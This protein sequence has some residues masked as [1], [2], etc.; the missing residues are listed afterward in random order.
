LCEEGKGFCQRR[1][2]QERHRSPLQW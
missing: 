2:C 1:E